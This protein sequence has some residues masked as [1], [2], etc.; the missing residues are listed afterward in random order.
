MRKIKQ[1][2]DP[3]GR[4]FARLTGELENAG[5]LAVEGQNR[6]LPPTQRS[7]LTFR[8]R[9]QLGRAVVTVDQIDAAIGQSGE[10]DR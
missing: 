7:R 9:R 6:D 4:L 8:L 5:E 1:N 10:I 2:R 3:I